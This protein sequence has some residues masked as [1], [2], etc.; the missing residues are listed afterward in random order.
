MEMRELV[1]LAGVPLIVALVQVSK[2]WVQ[3]ERY[4]PLLAMG[5]GLVLNLGIA[6]ALHSDL[7]TAIVYGIVAGLAAA[8]LYDVGKRS[9]LLRENS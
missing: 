7:A 9:N 8:G 4:W 6:L 3:D 1:G 5:W 2:A